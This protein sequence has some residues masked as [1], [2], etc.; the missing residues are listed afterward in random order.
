MTGRAKRGGRGTLM[1]LALF[2]AGSAALRIGSGVGQALAGSPDV[3]PEAES[4]EPQTC[5]DTP[6]ALA[7]ALSAREAELTAREAALKDRLAAL[8][9]A[10]QAIGTRLAALTAAEEELSKTLSMADG[11]SE[12]DL[13][14][15][16][17]VYETMKP[18]DAAALF[19]AMAPEFA[20]GFLGRMRPD[21]AA[22]VM[23]GLS[24]DAAYSISV[25]LAGRNALVPKE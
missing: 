25:L 14:R 9:L 12:A 21:A 6:L 3:K 19:Q 13:A 10:D 23:S 11:A 5:P 8:A 2:L 16:T 17:E 15:L 22:Q 4:A 24:S 18:K 20:A 7:E 1:I